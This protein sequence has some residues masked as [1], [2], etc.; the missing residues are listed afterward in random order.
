M[1][2]AQK[3]ILFCVFYVIV[4]REIIYLIKPI[5]SSSTWTVFITGCF[6]ACKHEAPTR[7][8]ISEFEGLMR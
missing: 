6:D 1:H 8:S 7:P 5:L 3:I 4:E 2:T